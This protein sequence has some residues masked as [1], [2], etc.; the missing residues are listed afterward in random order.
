MPIRY[1]DMTTC[2]KPATIAASEH[3]QSGAALVLVLWLLIVLSIMGLALSL[4]TRTG[5]QLTAHHLAETKARMAAEAG[6][7]HALWLLLNSN[8]PPPRHNYKLD[9]NGV[10]LDIAIVDEAGKIDING[11]HVHLLEGL[12]LQFGANVEELR[13]AILDWRDH[14]SEQRPNGAENDYYIAS[15]NPRG[16]RNTYFAAVSELQ[17][18]RGM[19]TKL[20]RQLEPH[21]TVYTAQPGIRAAAATPEALKSVPGLGGE[22]ISFYLQQRDAEP[23]AALAITQP[24]GNARSGMLWSITS[25]ADT[26]QALHRMRTVIQLGSGQQQPWLVLARFEHLPATTDAPQPEGS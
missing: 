12:L 26:G 2:S 20:F 5:I 3:R 16:A 13:D 14:D 25:V 24:Y 17:Q 10:Q 9:Y 22:D 4:Q 15:G 7:E 6:I 21:V 11:G 1:C 8:D 18:V 19:T 23:R